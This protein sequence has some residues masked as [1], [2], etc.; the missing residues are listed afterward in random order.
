MKV[1][2]RMA[3]DDEEGFAS[4][5]GYVAREIDELFSDEIAP[6][7]PIDVLIEQTSDENK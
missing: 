7:L 1:V 3:H 6:Q 2:E 4:L 5:K